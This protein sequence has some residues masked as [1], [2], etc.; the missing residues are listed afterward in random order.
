MDQ[1]NKVINLKSRILKHKSQGT[2]LT[3]ILELIRE[4]GCLSDIVGRDFEIMDKKGNVV[5]T[6]R[7]KPIGIKQ[8]NTLLEELHVLKKIDNEKEAAKWGKK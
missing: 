2:G 3:S 5:Y 1:Q 4:F 6:I 8:M 7:Q